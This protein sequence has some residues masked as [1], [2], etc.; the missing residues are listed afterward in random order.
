MYT[1]KFRLFFDEV[2]DFV[3]DIELLTDQSFLD[4]HRAII[5]HVKG[6]DGKELASF[7]VC[8]SKWNKLRE[9]T[10]IDM[11]DRGEDTYD[12]R[13]SIPKTTM[14]DSI[15]SD[16]IDEP[17]QRLMYE[18]DFLNLK[19]FFIELLK[20]SDSNAK[21]TYPRCTASAGEL[22]KQTNI[23]QKDPFDFSDLEENDFDEEN[24]ESEDFYDEEDLKNLSNDLEF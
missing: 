12:E 14:E 1:Y 15:L 24:E 16:F 18:F 9:I 3:R 10:L 20:S 2:E 11:D 17:H 7:Y 13:P 5:Q 4:F 21:L 6:L 22:P 8:N 19:T 23:L